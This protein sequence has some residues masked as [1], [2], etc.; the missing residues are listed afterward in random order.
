MPWSRMQRTAAATA[1]GVERPGGIS[2]RCLPEPL[3]EPAAGLAEPAAD[4]P[5][6]AAGAVGTAVED[7]GDEPQATTPRPDAH[8]SSAVA[9]ERRPRR[10]LVM[11]RLLCDGW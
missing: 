9:A 8:T 1:S 2:S 7:E 6:A 11:R 10:Q 3:A 5:E 4:P